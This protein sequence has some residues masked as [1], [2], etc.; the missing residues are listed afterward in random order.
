MKLLGDRGCGSGRNL[1]LTIVV[2]RSSWSRW[3]ELKEWCLALRGGQ[4][5]DSTSSCFACLLGQ[6]LN[7]S[8]KGGSISVASRPDQ[9][10]IAA[11]MLLPKP[12]SLGGAGGGG[13]AQP[14]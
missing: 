13:G 6:A 1:M 3:G 8:Q 7:F 11:C 10:L 14:G 12:L 2:F 4:R 9:P 5:S